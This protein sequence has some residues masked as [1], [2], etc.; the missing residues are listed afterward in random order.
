MLRSWSRAVPIFGPLV[1]VLTLVGCG[2]D[3]SGMSEADSRETYPAAPGFAPVEERAASEPVPPSFGFG[4]TPDSA[5]IRALDIDVM[6]DG[7]GLPPGSGTV[8]EGA[9]VYAA[10]CATCHG[11][12]G[13]GA[14]N[15]QLVGTTAVRGIDDPMTI[16]N[17]W[18]YATTLFDYI[19]RAMPYDRPGSLTDDEVYALVA[20]LLHQ[21]EIISADVSMDAQSLPRVEMPARDRF[22]PDDRLQYQEVR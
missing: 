18:P 13:E 5:W 3:R 4:E 22:V 7:T 20:W 16:G 1:L 15:D 19:R 8:Q 11:P 6:P 14:A 2:T 21:N 10:A 12:S 17:Y 9:E